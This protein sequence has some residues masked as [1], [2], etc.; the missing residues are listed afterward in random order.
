MNKTTLDF[1]DLH[2][3]RGDDTPAWKLRPQIPVEK[4]FAKKQAP[5]MWERWEVQ[6]PSDVMNRDAIHGEVVA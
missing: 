2:P 1:I 4:V 6:M 5:R 3:C